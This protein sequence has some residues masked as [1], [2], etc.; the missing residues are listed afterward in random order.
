MPL[1]TAL[2][3]YQTANPVFTNVFGNEVY[4]IFSKI[5]IGSRKKQLSNALIGG[6]TV[7]NRIDP[8]RVQVV[9][10]IRLNFLLVYGKFGMA[11][12]TR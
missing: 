10:R 9:E 3:K 12:L 7:K 6:K 4:M 1:G 11:I 2:K 5:G 8:V